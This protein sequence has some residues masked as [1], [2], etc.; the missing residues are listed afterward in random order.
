[1]IERIN[2]GGHYR[3]RA[4]AE[5]ILKRILSDLNETRIDFVLSSANGTFVDEAERKALAQVIPGALVYTP[6]PALGESVGAAGMWQ[7][8]IAA[9]ALR[10][11]ELP[12]LLHAELSSQLRI[13]T[14]RLSLPHANDAIVL[15]CGLNQQA[16]GLRL[17]IR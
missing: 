5:E 11:G 13:S 6:K 1:M 15:S 3:K 14:A 7:I 4:E 9:L 12:P 17:S 10:R 8:I 16:A 2:P